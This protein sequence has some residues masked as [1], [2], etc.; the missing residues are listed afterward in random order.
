[1]KK[2]SYLISGIILCAIG[3]VTGLI[4]LSLNVWHGYQVS[5]ILALI[6]FLAEAGRIAIP[7]VASLRGWNKG[8]II[9]LATCGIASVYAA[10]SNFADLN[11]H[12]L[13]AVESQNSNRDR[14][15]AE[16]NRLRAELAGLSVTEAPADL[17][18]LVAAHKKKA[19]DEAA[20]GFCGPKCQKAETDALAATERLAQARRKAELETRLSA[21]Q[22]ELAQSAVVAVSGLSLLIASFFGVAQDKVAL[23]E[24]L[25]KGLLSITLIELLV[26]L[27]IL[28]LPYLLVGLGKVE[29]PVEAEAVAVP[30]AASRKEEAWQRLVGMIMRTEDHRIIGSGRGLAEQLRAGGLAVSDS[31]FAGWLL[32]WQTQGKLRTRE[33]NAHKKEFSLAA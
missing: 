23:I 8:F 20:R 2:A 6:F 10:L 14:A 15:E 32:D 12:R 18:A 25:F 11:A 21:A 24:G 9:I 7:V 22:A 16:Y 27:P 29:E 30:L 33:V 13:L 1:M 3:V 5:L 28:G 17:E 19:S 26:Y 31:T 4:S